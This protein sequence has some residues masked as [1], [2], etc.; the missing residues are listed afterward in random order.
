MIW[1]FL[2]WN[3][4]LFR[5]NPEIIL[6]GWLHALLHLNDYAD[7]NEMMPA[8]ASYVEKNLDFFADNHAVWYDEKRNI[9]R[10]SDTS[11]QRSSY[12]HLR[13]RVSTLTVIYKAHDPRLKHYTITPV[14]DL[15]NEFSA[16]DV[17]IV[18]VNEKNHKMTMVVTCSELV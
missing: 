17:R 7:C 10:Y 13:R 18:A 4:R 6:N 8:I 16:F 1:K 12:S 15:E 11:P 9:S 14:L 3:S 2:S 5:S